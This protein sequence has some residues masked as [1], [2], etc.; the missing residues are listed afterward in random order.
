MTKSKIIWIILLFVVVLA[1][2]CVSEK[3]KAFP[4]TTPTLPPPAQTVTPAPLPTQEPDPV[5][6]LLSAM[7]T[8]QKVGQLLVA[9]IEGLTPGTDGAAAIQKYQV[10]GIILFGRNVESAAQLA[11][12]TN[13][14]KALNGSYVTLF[15][16]VDEEGGRVSRMPPEVQDLPSPYRY[17]QAG[18]EPRLW[19]GVL[20][21]ECRAFG[22]NM[23]FAPSLD[24]WSNPENTVIGDRAF[25]TEWEEVA[26]IA[27]DAVLG[28]SEC[29]VIP[30]V[31]HF[32]GHGDTSADSH[33]E[34]PVADKTLE[35]WMEQ[36][37]LPFRSA[38]AADAPAV[39]VGHILM[40]QLDPDYPASLSPK[41]VN[42]LLRQDLGF[43]GMVVTDDLTMGAI[44][45]TYG[46]GEAAVL[47]VEAGCD[48]LLVCHR[49]ENLAA[50]YDGLL[51][52]VSSGRVTVERLDQSV[53][54]ILKVKLDY[55]LTDQPIPI[56]D[57]AELNEKITAILP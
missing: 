41:V 32:P 26:R 18:G 55:Q 17:I 27:A 47:A 7:T 8:E 37:L 45:N 4:E 21:E 34:L 33:K 57:V 11:A 16:S 38:I 23:D 25:G 15:M 20:A 42:G 43:D 36:E 52:A 28:F 13:E 6:E 5:E 9:G 48:L 49:T 12:L 14:L 56:P 35:E 40:K 22:F 51:A 2:G 46:M 24:V 31:K 50:A 44:S 30:V 54:R 1:A 29:G 3:G 10:G 19:S 53:R 39:M